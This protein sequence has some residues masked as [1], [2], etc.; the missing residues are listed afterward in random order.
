M[1]EF[2]VSILI[3]CKLPM[4]IA[5]AYIAAKIAGKGIKWVWRKVQHECL[6]EPKFVFYR[7]GANR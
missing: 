5:A 2:M 1:I 3:L 7:M 4:G 6:M